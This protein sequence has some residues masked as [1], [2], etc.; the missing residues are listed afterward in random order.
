[1]IQKVSK[2]L[3]GVVVANKNIK[4][5]RAPVNWRYKKSPLQKQYIKHA[6]LQRP[7]VR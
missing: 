3:S 6:S 7:V 5:A 1:V 2:E 4:L